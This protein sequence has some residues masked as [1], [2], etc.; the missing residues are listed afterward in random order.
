MFK[1]GDLMRT[2]KTCWRWPRDEN[3][4]VIAEVEPFEA[5]TLVEILGPLI[6]RVGQWF[7]WLPVHQEYTSFATA[8]LG[9]KK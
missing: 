1:P 9:P 3:Q 5:G 6:K 2:N 8:T 4:N 7:V